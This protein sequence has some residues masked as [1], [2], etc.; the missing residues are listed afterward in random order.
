MSGS[1]GG[2]L[3]SHRSQEELRR[4]VEESLRESELDAEV[5]RMLNSE[6]ALINSRDTGLVNDRLDAIAEALGEDLI[7][8]DRLL[9]GGSVAKHTYVDGI[10]DIDSLIV[11]KESALGEDTPVAL[12]EAIEK[13]IKRNMP[14]GEIENVKSGFAVTVTYKDGGEIQLLPAVERKGE[15]AISDKQGSGWS[16]IRPKAFEEKLTAVNE[17]QG[18]HVVP[19]IKLA[20]AIIE[21]FAERDRPGGYHMEALAVAAF[22]GYSGPRNNRAMLTHFFETAAERIK[23]P[24]ADVTGQ[25]SR[26]DERLGPENS[27]DRQRISACLTRVAARMNSPTTTIEKWRKLFE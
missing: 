12:V 11:L 10:S 9:Y 16:L 6:L 14:A 20:K 27:S 15:I 17:K 22:E 4:E 13:A 26:I 24:I 19:T 1:G 18:R 5:N 3:H 8:I 7:E 21:S 23:R 25:S 2:G